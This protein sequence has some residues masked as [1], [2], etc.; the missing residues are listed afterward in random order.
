VI[1]V[2]FIQSW[3]LLGVVENCPSS[4]DIGEE[5]RF[6]ARESSHEDVVST[7][8]CAI[9]TTIDASAVLCGVST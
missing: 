6:L 2:R 8:A 3:S 4:I 7:I 1:D 9:E 5:Y